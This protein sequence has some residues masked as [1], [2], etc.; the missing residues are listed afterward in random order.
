MSYNRK[1]ICAL[2]SAATFAASLIGCSTNSADNQSSDPNTANLSVQSN[3]AETIDA[4]NMFTNRDLDD[5]FDENTAVK[6]YLKDNATDCDAKSVTIDGNTI[7]ITKEG[8]Y[9]LS[10]KLSEGQIVVNAEKTEKVQIVLDDVSITSSTSA[11]IYILQADKVFLTLASGSENTISTTDEFVAIDDNNID[12]AIFSKEDLTINGSGAL[13]ITCAYGHGIVSKDDLVIANGTYEITAKSHTISGKD[14]IRIANGTFTLSAGKD[15][16]HS[17]GIFY[18]ADGNISVETCYEGIEGQN[19][20]IDGGTILIQ[21]NDDGLN[22]SSESSS[23]TGDPFSVDDS[24][25]IT[26]NGGSITI[27]ANGD[28]IDSNGSLLVTGGEIYVTGPASNGDSALDYDGNATITGG[29]FVATGYSGMAQNFGSDS[30][31]GSM[32]V[33]LSGTTSD[34]VSLLDA[35]GK[36]LLSYSPGKAYNCVVFSCPEITEDGTYTVTA[37]SDSASITM[38]GLIYGTMGNGSMGNGGFDKGGK[39]NGDFGNGGMGNDGFGNG[40]RHDPPPGGRDF[41]SGDMGTP[42]SGD[43]GTPPSGDMGTPPSGDMGNPPSGDMG[44]PP[45]NAPQSPNAL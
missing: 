41:P 35:D 1:K 20:V 15:G 30:T 26:I 7:T 34:T 28:G 27:D 14:S 3:S 36:E 16:L 18:I 45:S 9:L 37:G 21:A 6:I 23:G 33:T 42:P 5:S 44:T 38:S 29:I 19:I 43:M 13:N 4:A 12:A 22:A 39:G 17:D 32:L 40:D 10:G 2:L 24:C 31:Q 11:A 25:M 8:T